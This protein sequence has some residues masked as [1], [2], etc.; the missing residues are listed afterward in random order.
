[1]LNFINAIDQMSCKWDKQDWF[2]VFKMRL[3]YGVEADLVELVQIPNVGHVRANRLKDKRIKTL[4]DFINYDAATLGKIMKC[5]TKLAEEALEG[6][7]LIELKNS[8]V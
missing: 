2:K 8:V 3:Q 6:A 1:M 5:S 4:G 7:R